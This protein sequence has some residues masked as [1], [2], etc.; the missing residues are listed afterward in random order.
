MLVRLVRLVAAFTAV[1]EGNDLFLVMPV[2]GSGAAFRN[3]IE[4]E[5]VV[6]TFTS[7]FR[8]MVPPM[9]STRDL[10][11]LRPRPLP[12]YLRDV[13]ASAWLNGLNSLGSCSAGI[14]IPVSCVQNV[15]C[16]SVSVSKSTLAPTVIDPF[17]VNFKLLLKR[18]PRI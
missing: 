9:D 11:M 8:E 17:A 6:P 14:P 10:Q 7:L 2:G 5:T 1:A 15:K 18:F 16:A 13:L 3:F 4:N 12:P